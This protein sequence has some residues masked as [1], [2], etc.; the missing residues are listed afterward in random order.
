MAESCQRP[1]TEARS[2]G[3]GSRSAGRKPVRRVTPKPVRRVTFSRPK[4][5]RRVTQDVPLLISLKGSARGRARRAWWSPVRVR[6]VLAPTRPF[7][8]RGLSP[9]AKRPPETPRG[10]RL[11]R[12]PQLEEP[13]HSCLIRNDSIE[14]EGGHFQRR[15]QVSHAGNRIPDP[16][17]QYQ[18]QSGNIHQSAGNI[19]TLRTSC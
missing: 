13:T 8:P 12:S 14:E 5:V 6:L 7:G 1:Q 17:Q 11:H 3:D 19:Y 9:A 16:G 2:F 10:C 18:H 4:P 15:L